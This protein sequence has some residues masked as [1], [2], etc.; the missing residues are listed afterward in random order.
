MG[1]CKEEYIFIFKIRKV[2]DGFFFLRK[3]LDMKDINNM[4]TIF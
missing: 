1:S 3:N 4:D 2:K